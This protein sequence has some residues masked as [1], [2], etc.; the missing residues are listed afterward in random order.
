[1]MTAPCTIWPFY[2]ENEEG[3]PVT[4]PLVIA[5]CCGCHTR[6]ERG[7]H[8]ARTSNRLPRR[9]SSLR[10]GIR[11]KGRQK[12][13][14]RISGSIFQSGCRAA[15]GMGCPFPS[16]RRSSYDHRPSRPTMACS[17]RTHQNPYVKTAR[18]SSNCENKACR[19]KGL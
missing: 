12:A 1:M 13:H 6:D 15:Q 5:K 17:P 9:Q 8:F 14:S 11:S 19:V 16:G 2:R 10:G 3:I 7:S 18:L 4:D